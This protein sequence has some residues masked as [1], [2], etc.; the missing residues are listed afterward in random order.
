[1]TLDGFSATE[2]TVAAAVPS[3]FTVSVALFV[4]PA[5]EA[6]IVTVVGAAGFDVVTKNEA[7]PANRPTVTYGGTLAIDGSLLDRRTWTSRS[8]LDASV[9]VA[10]LAG[11]AAIVAAPLT[12]PTDFRGDI[13]KIDVP[14]LIVH[15][16]ADNILPIDVT[17]RRFKELLPDATYV[18][19]EGAPHGMLLTHA[20][21]V[22]EALLAFVRS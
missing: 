6:V 7:P 20:A 4:T 22:N 17:A 13:A 1:M 21:E 5:P 8:A 19:I 14:A 2:A 12:W 11:N 3:G 10:N 9:Q 15:G 18:E 16:T